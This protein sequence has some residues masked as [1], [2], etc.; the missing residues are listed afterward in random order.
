MLDELDQS[1]ERWLRADVPLPPGRVEVSF[2]QPKGDWDARRSQ[3]L[4]NLFL[5]AVAPSVTR[6]V[7]RDTRLVRHDDGRMVRRQHMPVMKNSYLVSV[8]GGG[9]DVE[10][11]IL[12]RVATTLGAASGV[13]I[14]HRGERL[15]VGMAQIT[16]LADE[17]PDVP[18]LWSA[19]DVPA[20]PA[21]QLSVHTVLGTPVDH[22]TAPSPSSVRLRTESTARG[23]AA[24]SER[25]RVF[26]R[27]SNANQPPSPRTASTRVQD[28]ARDDHLLDLRGDDDAPANGTA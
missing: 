6:A 12:G 5:Y 10:H 18:A 14:E 25:R 27:V 26:A 1:L 19:L 15:R 9:A 28:S 13:P 11:E 22:P 23:T 3:P 24:Y 17:R 2:D 7:N 20:R 16:L 4:V 8:W 21:L